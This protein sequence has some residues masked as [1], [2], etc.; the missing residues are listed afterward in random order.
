MRTVGIDLDE[1]DA[2]VAVADLTPWVLPNL[3][4]SQS[5]RCRAAVRRRER[6]EAHCEI[7][8]RAL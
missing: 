5:M 7:V 2:V 3:D 4:G 8:R 6:K 1:R